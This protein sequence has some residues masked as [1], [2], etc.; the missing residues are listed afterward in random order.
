MPDLDMERLKSALL[1]DEGFR[2]SAYHDTA[3]PPLL[4]IGIGRMID[5]S[6]GGGI[7][8][9]EAKYLLENDLQKFFVE[10]DKN[11][12][13]WREMPA[14]A[15]EGLVNM[16]FNMGYPRLSGFKNM[17]TALQE[18]DY[19]AAADEALDSQWSVQVGERSQR[20]AEMFRSC[21]IQGAAI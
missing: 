9:G 8:E 11:A 5:A 18:G 7:S 17:M 4:T 2:S 10:L 15:Q 1:R 13:W 12:D 16:C 21:E 20:I 6:E 14:L 19:S 3:D